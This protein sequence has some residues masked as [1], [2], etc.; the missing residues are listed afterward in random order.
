MKAASKNMLMS[1][2]ARIVSL[3]TG[4]IVQRYLLLYFGST[5]NGLTTSINQAMAYLVLLEA[6][7]GTASVQALYDPLANN[8]W[9]LVSGILTATGKEYKK[10]SAVFIVT[11]AGVSIVIPLA[12]SGEVEFA[13]AGILT[14]ITGGSYIVSYV[15]GGKYKALLDADKKLY[16]L[17][18][19]EIL[20]VVM[21][22]LFRV[23]ALTR[24]YGIVLVQ[25]INLLCI[26]TKN[27]GYVIYVRFKYKSVNY[28]HTPNY[29]AV[30]KRWNVLIHSVAG[31]VVNN[32]DVLILTLFGS[33]KTVSV[34]GIYN[35][36]FGQLSSLIQTTFMQA[37]QSS[38]GQLYY[39][40][41]KEY[42]RT[43]ELYQFSIAFLLTW[44]CAIAIGM[45]LPF[46]SIYT[47]GVDDIT[48]I[49][50]ILPVLFMLILLMNQIR[51]PALIT[52][53]VA[54][55]F[56]ETQRG[57]IIEALIN[58]IVSLILFFC[59]DLG[60]Y[61]LLIGT[62]C[63][64]MFRSMDVLI[65]THK[66]LVCMPLRRCLRFYAVD[67]MALLTNYLFFFWIFPIRAD[68]VSQ[69]VLN[70]FAV[71][72]GTLLVNLFYNC[73]WNRQELKMI[74]TA[75]KSKLAGILNHG[76]K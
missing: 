12:V 13:T 18:T 28:R 63:S 57:A 6:G 40:N 39:R 73:L 41:K 22:C 52:I 31:I 24:G 15:M 4:L 68:S 69:W 16:I 23:I 33:L 29:N 47:N 8:N 44:I 10:I 67:F 59:T 55:H 64:Y 36:V 43:Y 66:H 27:I 50:N 35:T 53:N 37:P 65:Y 32:T 9:E 62:V 26:C 61:G 3:A 48:Y 30:N 14:L 19:F 51:I 7:L 72:I 38:F 21:S 5:L 49:D 58:L 1:I 75:L 25:L 74:L 70:A 34:Y 2:A 60:L 45:I 54:G 42:S 20:S 71:G 17:Y 56:R 76:G 46:V 11:L